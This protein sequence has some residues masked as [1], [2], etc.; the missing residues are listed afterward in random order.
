MKFI[1]LLTFIGTTSLVH[2]QTVDLEQMKINQTI[3]YKLTLHD[4]LQSDLKIDSIIPVPEIMDMSTAD[5]LIYVSRSYF[6]YYSNLGSCIIGVIEFDGRISEVRMGDLIL[7]NKTTV[8]LVG[9]YFPENCH[10][11]NPIQV[12]QNSNSYSVCSIPISANGELTDNKLIFFF[13]EGKLARIDFWE[14]S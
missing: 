6:K 9:E 4:L 13:L 2:A 8:D 10:E 14:P 3:E 11:I 5:S 12:Y 1:L 7:T